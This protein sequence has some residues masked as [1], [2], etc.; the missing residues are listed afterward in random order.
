[1][2]D[3]PERGADESPTRE[4]PERDEPT[5]ESE[6]MN[7]NESNI[8]DPIS[9]F[10]SLGTSTAGNAAPSHDAPAA[11]TPA[12]G[13]PPSKSTDL[14]DRLAG[15]LPPAAD[16]TAEVSLDDLGLNLD[17]L[18]DT[19]AQS[20]LS[21]SE[22]EESHEH[23]A[24][25]PTMVAGIDERSRRMIENVAD[26]SEQATHPH[27]PPEAAPPR[28]IDLTSPDL[29]SPD[30]SSQER[31]LTELERELESSFVSDLDSSRTSKTVLL[32]AEAAPTV[33][34]SR[35]LDSSPTTRFDTRELTDLNEAEKVDTESTSKLRNIS[36]DSIDLDLDRLASALGGDTVQQPRAEEDL[37]SSEVFELP[38]TSETG[39]RMRRIDLDVGDAM[40]G[41]DAPTNRI[42]TADTS[43]LKPLDLPIPE[44]EPVTM[45]EVGT[46]L[47]LARAY[48]DMGDPDGARSILEEVV[49]EGSASQ[50]QEASRLIESLP[51]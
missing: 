5:V 31:D 3:T 38:Q 32:G 16:Q 36:S 47:D 27:I 37:F 9:N 18:D 44:L 20:A 19:G 2:L 21:L 17:S 7:F 49:Q 45:S 11:G 25:A 12:A 43:K 39:S 50:K 6:L 10:N 29:K 13:T 14:R 22:L 35:E 46:K 8:L 24:D 42:D 15:K 40:T 48:M 26:Q 30:F 51:G 33:L 23:P 34:M 28:T 4:M 1:M 41:S